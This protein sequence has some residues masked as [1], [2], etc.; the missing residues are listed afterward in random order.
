M[1]KT[2]NEQLTSVQDAIEKIE[3][4]AQSASIDGMQVTRADI[5]TLYDREAHLLRKIDLVARGAGFGRRVVEF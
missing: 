5:H 2:L 4:G 3:G 1:A